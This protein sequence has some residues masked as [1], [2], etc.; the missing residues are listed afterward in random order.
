MRH[1]AQ[2]PGSLSSAPSRVNNSGQLSMSC[3]KGWATEDFIRA[4]ILVKESGRYNF[5]G[6][7]IPLPTAIRFDRL[8]E[9]LGDDASPKERRMLDLLKYG[10]PIDCKADYGVTKRQK[11]TSRQ[12]VSRVL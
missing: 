7:R 6:C 4:H 5:E 8:E 12:L 1:P 9:A 3:G 10:M 11:N 2:G